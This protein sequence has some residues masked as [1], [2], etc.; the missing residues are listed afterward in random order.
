MVTFRDYYDE[1]DSGVLFSFFIGAIVVAQLLLGFVFNLIGTGIGLTA[2]E[3]SKNALMNWFLQGG[4]YVL[5]FF[6]IFFYFRK[7]KLS[8][9]KS[10]G[11]NVKFKFLDYI[12]FIVL[13]AGM[14]LALL[15]VNYLFSALLEIIKY[16]FESSSLDINSAGTFIAAIFIM[17]VLPSVTEETVFRGAVLSGFSKVFSKRWAIV[18]SS[19]LFMIMHMYFPQFV[20][21]FLCGLIMAVLVKKTGSVIPAMIVHFINNFASVLI[22]FILSFRSSD[23]FGESNAF[24]IQTALVFL[25]I[26][27]IGTGLLIGGFIYVFKRFKNQEIQ[28]SDF[29]DDA[30][31]EYNTNGLLVGRKKSMLYALPGIVL[32]VLMTF[33]RIFVI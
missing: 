17:C 4:M 3:I 26:S 25:L 14:F 10:N 28:K 9:V 13:A 23:S 20:N 5:L 1:K 12:M 2:Q 30:L 33:L 15:I 22:T 16:P 21:T 31:K 11:L 8:I 32:A 19:L 6:V 7:N 24:N 18:I 29:D 27:V